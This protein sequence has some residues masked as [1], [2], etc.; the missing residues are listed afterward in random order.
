[1]IFATDVHEP[2]APVCLPDG[3]LLCTEMAPDRGC[4]S[5]LGADGRSKRIIATTGRPNGL[6]VDRAGFIWVAESKTPALLR[7]TF[8]GKVETIL[9]EC[10]GERF[11]FPNDL[12]FGPDGALYM[13][14]S[15]ILKV[16]FSPGSRLRDD[17]DT[18]PIDGRVY[19][20]DTRTRQIRRLDHGFRFANGIAFDSAGNLYV[21]ET[22]TGNVYRYDAQGDGAF[23]PRQVFGNVVD[24]TGQGYRGPD[25]MKFAADGK[26]YCAVFG[27]G[28]VTVLGTDG[29]LVRRIKLAGRRPTNVAFGLA[30]QHRI[31]VT[32]VEH[33]QIETFEV[34]TD[35][36]P[37][38]N[39]AA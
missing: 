36:L 22:L 29:T 5:H 15:G 4:V 27:Q 14:D 1:M 28:D 26:L 10:A 34:E 7:L 2:E 3:T 17:W 18:V 9:T 38:L 30:G 37:L 20:I 13:T 35:G 23:G 6:A 39:G 11:L 24:P 33:G 16:E 32:E 31:Y 25:G 21:N 12:A 19:R 8:D